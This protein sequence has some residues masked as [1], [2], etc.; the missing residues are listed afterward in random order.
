MAYLSRE[1]NSISTLEKPSCSHD[2]FQ[3]MATDEYYQ[4][5]VSRFSQ[6]P[7]YP[8]RNNY[9]L[10][11]VSGRPVDPES[12]NRDTLTRRSFPYTLV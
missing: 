3:P 12:L 11:N 2:I 10:I 9:Q 7:S 6:D 1:I 4:G 5:N 8:I